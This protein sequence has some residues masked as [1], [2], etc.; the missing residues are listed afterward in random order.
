M[1]STFSDWLDHFITVY[2]DDIL[3]YSTSEEQH[4]M[5]LRMV[6][7]RLRERKLFAKRSKCDFGG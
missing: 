3:V 4:E 7:E 5:H 2:L 6:F 1:N